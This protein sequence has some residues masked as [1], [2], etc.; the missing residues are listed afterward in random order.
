MWCELLYQ[1]VIL[2]VRKDV[3]TNLPFSLMK[4]ILMTIQRIR[5]LTTS[6]ENTI[7]CVDD[8]NDNYVLGKSRYG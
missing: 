5:R 6:R 1:R 2:A 4:V 3:P 8:F 7:K